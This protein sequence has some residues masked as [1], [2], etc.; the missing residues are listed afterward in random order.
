MGK[1]ILSTLTAQ[2][3]S[4]GQLIP[5]P[6]QRLAK[7]LETSERESILDKHIFTALVEA[8]VQGFV[9]TSSTGSKRQKHLLGCPSE[10]T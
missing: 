7:H 6:T 9:H 10:T 8:K 1:A 5:S 3:P 2:V 4:Q